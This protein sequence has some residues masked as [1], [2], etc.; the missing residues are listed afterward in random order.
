MTPADEMLRPA[1]RPVAVKVYGPPEPP[2]PTSV[3]G[4]IATPFIAL[5]DTQVALT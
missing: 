3:T 2:L 1:G 5:I 4:V